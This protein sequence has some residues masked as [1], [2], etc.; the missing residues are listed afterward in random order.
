MEIL[1]KYK[2]EKAV[3]T[4]SLRTNL[5]N[6]YISRRH[7]MATNGMILVLVPAT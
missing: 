7:A 5:Q 2:L 6:I 4:D 1:K 3:S